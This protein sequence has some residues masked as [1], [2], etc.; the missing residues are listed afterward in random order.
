[1]QIP[2][3][4]QVFKLK[5]LINLSKNKRMPTKS[6]VLN[7]PYPI[8][9]S[10]NKRWQNSFIFSVFV[11]LFLSIFKPFE[12]SKLNENILVIALGYGLVCFFVM[13]LL[14]VAVF[15]AFPVFFAEDKWTVKR[16]L[17]WSI[18][19]IALIGFGNFIYS[20][21]I[22]IT[23]FS[24]ISLFW[25]EFYTLA[26]G[27][28]PIVASVLINQLRLN[29]KFENESEKINPLIEDSFKIQS[30]NKIEQ[31]K[32]LSD[33][34][35]DVLELLLQDFV[36]AKSDD[37]YVEIFYSKNN[38]LERKLLRNTL[39]NISNLLSTNDNFFRCHKS[40]LIN[41]K[42]VNHISGNAQG[43][44]LHIIGTDEVVPVSRTKNKHIQQY[45]T[46][47]H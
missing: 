21:Y 2:R 24:V 8:I 6:T 18:L 12:L 42:K 13:A 19:N 10:I 37:N 28:F 29:S 43:L 11:V 22:G 44:K 5:I 38:K 16:E 41:L 39:T 20:F 46:I 40:Y 31:I 9:D 1:M 26:I 4:I 27:I 17:L 23:N 33:S 30:E 3:L 47:R 15:S 7:R 34:G 45:F 25:F 36:F 35:T 32:F 14:N